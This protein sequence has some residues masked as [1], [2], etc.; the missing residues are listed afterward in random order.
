MRIRAVY[1]CEDTDFTWNLVRNTAR[2]HPKPFISGVIKNKL[3]RNIS[4][5]C[6]FE[7]SATNLQRPWIYRTLQA[8][9]NVEIPALLI[10]EPFIPMRFGVTGRR[11]VIISRTTTRY[12]IVP[13]N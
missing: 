11:M 4:I 13:A 9:F 6:A 2:Y 1:Y 5:L 12:R 10:L 7:P 8:Y 3:E